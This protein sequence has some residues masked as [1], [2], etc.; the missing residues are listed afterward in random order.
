MSTRRS[1][2]SRARKARPSEAPQTDVAFAS[3]NAAS[4]EQLGQLA[5]AVDATE[6]GQLRALEAGWDELLT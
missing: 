4:L 6:T 2:P 1:R 3:P 5:R